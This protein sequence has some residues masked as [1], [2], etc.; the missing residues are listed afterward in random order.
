MKKL[1]LENLGLKIAAV[2]LSIV[3]WIFVTSRGQ[4]EIFIDVP[5]EFKNILSGLEVVNHS[6]KT[7]SLNIKG[8]ERLI[9]NLKSSDIK[10][11]VDLNKTKK[12]ENIYHIT[13]ADIKLPHGIIVSSINPPSVKVITEETKIKTVKVIPFIIGEIQKGFYLKS[14]DVSPQS[15][16]VEGIKSEIGKINNIKTEPLD[17]SGISE[18]FTQN[19][20]LDLSGRNI[21]TNIG[22]VK[23]KVVIE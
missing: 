12:G 21:R 20:K 10:V 15:V 3:L 7:V 17:I 18:T 13:R 11:Y 8:Q 23:V 4:L 22:E 16:E 1:F 9:N 19:V 5:L 14:V 6:V 2:L